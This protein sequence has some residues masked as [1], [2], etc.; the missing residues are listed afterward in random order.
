MFRFRLI[1]NS[2]NVNEKR[3][4]KRVVICLLV[5]TAHCCIV[6]RF[7]ATEGV[8]RSP[9]GGGGHYR[10]SNGV[11]PITRSIVKVL[12]AGPDRIATV[13][14]RYTVR[15]RIGRRKIERIF[16]VAVAPF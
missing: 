10:R 1:K 3:R 4:D 9:K 15:R 14:D 13:F 6:T 16:E 7:F 11:T 12:R 2:R 8:K 5:T